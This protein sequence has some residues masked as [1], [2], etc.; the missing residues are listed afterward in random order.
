MISYHLYIDDWSV[1]RH[2][3]FTN[4]GLQLKD[5]LIKLQFTELFLRPL[6]NLSS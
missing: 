2:D 1:R 4:S 6:R 3:L 5:M